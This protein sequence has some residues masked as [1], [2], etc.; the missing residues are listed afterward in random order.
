MLRLFEGV[1]VS[2][3]EHFCQPRNR[4]RHVRAA[5]RQRRRQNGASTARRGGL[6]SGRPPRRNHPEVG[7]VGGGRD[8]A[9][10]HSSN[11]TRT[12]EE[13]SNEQNGRPVHAL[14]P[15]RRYKTTLYYTTLHTTIQ[16]HDQERINR[17][18]D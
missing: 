13:L 12:R 11:R 8:H 4:F 1:D 15:N 3:G 16:E 5:E 9:V 6:G 14:T 7:P 10:F 17:I 18:I 2:L